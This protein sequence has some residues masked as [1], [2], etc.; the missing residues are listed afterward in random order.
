MYTYIY[1]YI[2]IYL[3][4]Y[5]Y[6]HIVFFCFLL[7]QSNCPKLND[8]SPLWLPFGVQTISVQSMANAS[9]EEYDIYQ[10]LYI[11]INIAVFS[12]GGCPRLALKIIQSSM[13]FCKLPQ[14][15]EMIRAEKWGPCF[16]QPVIFVCVSLGFSWLEPDHIAKHILTY[17]NSNVL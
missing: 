8:L 12:G 3:Y 4:V 1:M 7:K 9:M 17:W 15:G 13:I 5:M 6:I 11:Y 16:R 10:N 14:N 2:Y